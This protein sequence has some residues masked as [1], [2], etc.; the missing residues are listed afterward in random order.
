MKSNKQCM[1]MIAAVS[2]CLFFIA[3]GGSAPDPNVAESSSEGAGDPKALY[4]RISDALDETYRE[5]G[6][7]AVNW[8]NMERVKDRAFEQLTSPSA[9]PIW[10]ASWSLSVLDDHVAIWVEI[11]GVEKSGEW[12]P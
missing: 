4:D 9:E 5:L 6:E 8:D 1:V 11:E 7:P 3:C 12:R 2:T 10:N